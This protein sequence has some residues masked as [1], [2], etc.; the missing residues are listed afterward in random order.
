MANQ[1]ENRLFSFFGF[2]IWGDIANLTMYRRYDGRLVSF[3]KTWPDKPP[4]EKQLAD[5]ARFKAAATDRK[6]T[7]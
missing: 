7:L 2:V 3:A 6:S 5:R 1:P 4:S